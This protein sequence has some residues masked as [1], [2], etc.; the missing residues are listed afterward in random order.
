MESR[1]ETSL[2]QFLLRDMNHSLATFG[3]NAGYFD[4]MMQLIYYA[5]WDGLPNSNDQFWQ[6]LEESFAYIEW[7]ILSK[8]ESREEALERDEIDKQREHFGGVIRY[9]DTD[10]R[11][12]LLYFREK[13]I[14]L[15]AEVRFLLD[16]RRSTRELLIRWGELMFCHGWMANA[17][18]S[19]GDDL[20][21]KRAAL[22]GA[23]AK[24]RDQQ[25]RWVA[26]L[27]AAEL[28]Q[29]KARKLADREVAKRL[30]DAK[31]T[32]RLP[33]EISGAWIALILHANG[34]LRQTYTQKHLS[35]K[36]IRQL[37]SEPNNDLPPLD[38]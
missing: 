36:E 8:V 3:R 20:G 22:Q 17:V 9:R 21:Y 34:Q 33:P 28:D 13:G 26:H 16:Q 11:D 25:K 14:D 5:A 35:E 4:G 31:A 18:F 2:K 38:F 15:L 27:L 12:N 30:N 23:K 24:S 32:G 6:R 7:D 19:G 29:G 10:D 1:S 37:V